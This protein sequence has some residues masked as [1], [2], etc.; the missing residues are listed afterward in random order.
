MRYILRSIVPILLL[1]SVSPAVSEPARYARIVLG[2]RE[3]VLQ[4]RPVV[5]DGIVYA[6][7]EI[8]KDIEADHVVGKHKVSIV[9]GE[10]TVDLDLVDHQGAQMVRVDE[11]ARAADLL[12]EWND[13]TS[14]VRLLA[15]LVSIEFNDSTLTARFTMPVPVSSSRLW[16]DPWKIWVDVPGSKIGTS[17][18]A[19]PGDGPDVTQVRLGQFTDDT[20]RIVIDLNKKVGYRVLTR[21][22]TREVKVRITGVP[23]PAIRTPVFDKTEEEAEAVTISAISIEPEDESKVK[24]RITTSGHAGFKAHIL[25][26][27]PRIVVDVQNATLA[28]PAE[29]M[30][31]E[32][33]I[34][35]RIRTGEQDDGIRVVLDLAR[36]TA[37][38]AELQG[39]DIVIGMGLPRSAGGKLADKLVVLDP[40]HGGKDPGARS[41][42]FK[43]KDINLLIARRIKAALEEAGARVIMTREDDTFIELPTRPAIADMHSADFFISVHCNALFPEKRTGI[44][45]YY[46]PGQNSSR[47]L[48]HAIHDKIIRRTGMKDNG[49]RR[50]TVLYQSG[51]AVLRKATV[52]AVLIECG[53]IDCT[54]DRNRLCDDSYRGELA[55]AVVEGLREYVEGRIEAEVN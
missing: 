24:A 53:Y 15:R 45:T 30:P 23:S 10:G 26:D 9:R 37:F 2:T 41:S 3:A 19:F 25:S 54:V 39:N 35:K 47:T 46:H 11:V 48:A 6:P 44:E 55:Q 5:E 34:L 38:S 49:V 42:G 28:L 8:L 17:E 50:D 14:T 1:L 13:A 51:L 36:Y 33:P 4:R 43:E 12:Y 22:L 31:V 32:H 18:S 7:V 27:P 29:D 52:P 40:G 20:T 21:G 16:P